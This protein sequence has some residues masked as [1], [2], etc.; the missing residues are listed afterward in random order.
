[1]STTKKR[2]LGRGLATLLGDIPLKQ[3]GGPAVR[4][5]A[6]KEI[7]LQSLSVNELRPGKYQPRKTMDSQLLQELAE[8]IKHSGV[9]Q[10]I[11][12]RKS[13]SGGYEIIA[14]ER[15]WRAAQLAGLADVPVVIKNI[16]DHHASAIALIENIQREDLNALEEAN[17]MHR[18][19]EEFGLTHEDLARSVGKSRTTISNLLRV[20]NLNPDVQKL[21]AQNQIELGHA[22][23][24]L[25]L[26][27]TQQSQAAQK[28]VSAGYSV[29]ETEQYVRHV[30]QLLASGTPVA[31]RI[32]PQVRHIQQRL[33]E[34]LAAKVKLTCNSKGKGNIT[35][36][37]NS[38]DELQGILEHFNC[39]S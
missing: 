9:I 20:L 12:V 6:D 38:L 25:S 32:D 28:V 31:T 8:S 1:M 36:V 27:G 22:K 29:R 34:A 33:S 23:A 5:D 21:L 15:R 16:D 10:P 13:V 18:L 3:A 19:I 2:G 7:A 17:A 14:G 39:A 24:L 26:V 4:G 35:I 11:V 37:Y 30:A